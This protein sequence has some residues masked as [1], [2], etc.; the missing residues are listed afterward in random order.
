MNAAASTLEQVLLE[1][2]LSQTLTRYATACD[3]R[4]WDLLQQVF[5]PDCTTVYGG[6]YTCEGVARVRHMISTHLDGCGPTQHLLANLVVDVDTPEDDSAEGDALLVSSRTA[7]RASHRGAGEK[8]AQT[9][10]CMGYYHDRWTHTPA[11]WRIAHRKMVV[12]FE[13]GSRSVLAP[14]T[15]LAAP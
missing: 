5:T 13:F 15:G 14:P 10:E 7:V 3:T 11:G 9:Y 2:A 1:H 8:A 12:G 6:S 4:N